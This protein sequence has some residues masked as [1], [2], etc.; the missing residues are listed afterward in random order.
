[1][2]IKVKK[3]NKLCIVTVI[4]FQQIRIAENHLRSQGHVPVH[5]VAVYINMDECSRLIKH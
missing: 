2:G 4:D 1:M 5:S 3:H